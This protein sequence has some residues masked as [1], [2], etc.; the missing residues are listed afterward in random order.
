MNSKLIL[1]SINLTLVEVFSQNLTNT[2]LKFLSYETQ[3]KYTFILSMMPHILSKFFYFYRKINTFKLRNKQTNWQKN[4]KVF[5]V[6]T[7]FIQVTLS[8]SFSTK[9]IFCFLE[10]G[11]RGAGPNPWSYFSNQPFELF[12]GFPQNSR[13]HGLESFGKTP[14]EGT[15]DTGPDPSC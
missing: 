3:M 8:L 11:R 10:I 7:I 9:K 2:Y 12:S 13:K 6:G 5:E 14:K 1:Y 4:R 15:L